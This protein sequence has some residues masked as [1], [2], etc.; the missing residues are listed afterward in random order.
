MILVWLFDILSGFRFTKNPILLHI[1]FL[2]HPCASPIHQICFGPL[3][4][5]MEKIFLNRKH[6]IFGFFWVNSTDL[7][8]CIL[9]TILVDQNKTVNRKKNKTKVDRRNKNLIWITLEYSWIF[10]NILEFFGIFWNILE[11]FG[12]FW[13]ILEYFKTFEIF[14]NA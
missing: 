7:Q 14:W 12:I 9:R 10:W 6:Y 5:C 3:T 13:N 2:S 11:Y 4:R 8:T 1:Q